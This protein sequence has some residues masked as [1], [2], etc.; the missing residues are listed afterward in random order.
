MNTVHN[1][2]TQNLCIVC[3]IIKPMYDIMY[4][5]CMYV[6]TFNIHVMYIYRGSDFTEV[7]VIMYFTIQAAQIGKICAFYQRQQF[8]FKYMRGIHTKLT[9][10]GRNFRTVFGQP[11]QPEISRKPQ[12]LQHICTVHTGYRYT[13]KFRHLWPRLYV[14][15]IICTVYK[16]TYYAKQTIPVYLR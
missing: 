7:S 6:H 3:T 8:S 13:H 9:R 2:H 12:L 1:V 4:D 15:S 11:R 16:Q 10:P 14:C 5:I